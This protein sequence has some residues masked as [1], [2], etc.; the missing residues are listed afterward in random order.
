MLGSLFDP[1][2][3]SYQSPGS[4]PPFPQLPECYRK[5]YVAEAPA[6]LW[7]SPGQPSTPSSPRDHG[8]CSNNNWHAW[9]E[10]EGQTAKGPIDHSTATRRRERCRARTRS[11]TSFRRVEQGQSRFEI[12]DNK[13]QM[14]TK[15]QWV[16]GSKEKLVLV[17]ICMAVNWWNY[18]GNLWILSHH[19]N[20]VRVQKE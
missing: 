1:H 20:S 5:S 19:G 6:R 14:H 12:K 4:L 16:K 17:L 7:E 8:T 15:L 13:G 9:N 10:R 11:D 18:I 2:A 3:L